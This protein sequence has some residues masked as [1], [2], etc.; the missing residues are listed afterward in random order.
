[1]AEEITQDADKAPVQE[2]TAS[3]AEMP[4]EA[5]VDDSLVIDDTP[6][7]PAPA[8]VSEEVKADVATSKEQKAT[9]EFPYSGPIDG[10]GTPLKISLPSSFPDET[11]A[12]LQETPNVQLIDDENSRTWG[13][14][15]NEGQEFTTF[16]EAFIPTLENQE[17]D[18]QQSV[19]LDGSEKLMARA[20]MFK[21]AENVVMAGERACLH[22]L[23]HIGVGSLFQSPLWHSGFWV[24]FK[25]PTESEIIEFNRQLISD[26]IE[27]G[28]YTY[29]LMF[30]NI[31]SYTIDRLVTFALQH[32]YSTTLKDVQ[33]DQLRNIIVSQDIP[34]L[35]W[36][37]VC[38][39]YPNGFQYRRACVA[40]P[41]K[42]NYVLEE[43]LNL[44]KLLW[45]NN[46]A[47]TDWQKTHMSVRSANSRD[48]D[49]VKRYQ[50]EMKKMQA[51]QVIFNE[52][53]PS[54]VKMRLTT[55]SISK[56]VESGH[57]W[58][59]S[60][61]NLVEKSLAVST[62][63][64]ERNRFIHM[65]ASANAMRQYAHWVE[66]IEFS[67]KNIEDRDTINDALGIMSSDD[68]LRSEFFN[69]VTKYINDS[70]IAVVGIPTFDCP[71][72]GTPQEG[73]VQ[74]KHLTTIIPLDVVNLFFGLHGQRL[75]R[76][77]ER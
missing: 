33:A 60:I 71:V 45:V 59:G 66:H 24:T 57:A 9:L 12:A 76:I 25:P 1:M 73:D 8:P 4:S 67:S 74:L 56:Y 43:V 54:E 37:F 69:A 29:G 42:C 70:T 62:T 27:F 49:S 50:E 15:V 44:S 39:M 5:V 46:N 41:E 58:I 14:V 64:G 65:H 7:Q 77:T 3:E 22:L 40:N 18:F 68:T 10:K 52:G 17:A 32:V 55:P 23:T 19:A 6:S 51:R 75:F 28:R 13:S 30:S 11:L 31:T 63:D 53:Q 2:Q 20:P 38:T 72:C 21:P 36:G 47:F 34:S 16:A 61:V 35:I 26:K 48:L